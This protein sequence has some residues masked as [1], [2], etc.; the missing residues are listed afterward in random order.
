[1]KGKTTAPENERIVD[2]H[3]F[4]DAIAENLTRD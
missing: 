2:M 1:L 4:L 3:G